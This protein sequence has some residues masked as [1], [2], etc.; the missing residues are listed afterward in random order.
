MLVEDRQHFAANHHSA[1][2]LSNVPHPNATSGQRLV[3]ATP[4]TSLSLHP[5]RMGSLY[6]DL[7]QA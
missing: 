4:D 5:L 6:K 7:L 1:G 3:A 2:R